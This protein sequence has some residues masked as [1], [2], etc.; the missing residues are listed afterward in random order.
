MPCDSV[1]QAMRKIIRLT[2]TATEEGGWFKWETE[3]KVSFGKYAALFTNPKG[4]QEDF[5]KLMSDYDKG[6]RE[7]MKKYARKEEKHD[8]DYAI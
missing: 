4:F 6:L 3:V 1:V 8:G 7:L 5:S 2:T